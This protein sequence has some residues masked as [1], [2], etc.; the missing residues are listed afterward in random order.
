[1]TI[2]DDED[3]AIEGAS[4]ERTTNRP[5][6]DPFYD[7]TNGNLMKEPVVGP[8]G[9][10]HEKST[11]TDTDRV[12][13]Y[14]NRALQDIIEQE[15]A[16][17]STTW[18]GSVR[19]L[20]NAMQKGWG[21]LVSKSAFGTGDFRPLPESFYCPITCDLI[22][23]PVVSKEGI[24]YERGAIENWIRV[25][26]KSPMTRNLLAASDLRENNAIYELI[27]LEKGRTL[28]SIHPSIR[29]WKESG[30]ATTRPDQP[31]PSAPAA[32]PEIAIVSGTPV[33]PSGPTTENELYPINQA[34]IDE[35]RR[36]MR[37]QNTQT[38]YVVICFSLVVMFLFFPYY[39]GVFLFFAMVA[40]PFICCCWLCAAA[41]EDG[42]RNP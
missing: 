37:R 1:M 36:R 40:C 28:D 11:L 25:N 17:R 9:E 7:A 18:V 30:T 26:G 10:S 33:E 38:V 2:K 23:D 12:T 35:R 29:R 5:F 14:P 8:D 41:A 32:E 15:V 31:L 22:T 13:Y 4:S 19:R 24:T 3:I 27:Q 6:P 16:L 42:P 34:E 20:D 39:F 21:R